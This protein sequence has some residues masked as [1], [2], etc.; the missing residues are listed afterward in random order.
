MI[1]TAYIGLGG[2][3]ADPFRAI[4]KAIDVLRRSPGILGVR[5]SGCYRTL[6]VESSGPDFCNAV[7]EI[8]TTLSAPDVLALLLS[9]E[10]QFGRERS[11]RNAPRTLDL[12]LIAYGDV[13]QD[14]PMVTLPHPRAHLRAFVLVP[15]CELNP[16]VLLGPVDSLTLLPAVDW[17]AKL[18]EPAL[19]EVRP[20]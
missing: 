7:A 6:P 2:N 14:N 5:S 16:G 17:R 19:A 20:W 4:E 1:E 12:D 18:S 8:K 10:Q 13:R 9:I 15:L 3:L 11:V